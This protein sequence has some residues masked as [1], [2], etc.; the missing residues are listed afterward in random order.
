[1]TRRL[2]WAVSFLAVTVLAAGM[3]VY[4]SADGD[5]DTQPWTDL[6]TSNIPAAVTFAAIGV[7]V[8]W[9][10]PHFEHAYAK[11]GITMD[12]EPVVTVSTLTAV[13]AAVLALIA[14]FGVDLTQAQT[15]AILGL[16]AVLAPLVVG[17][18]ARRWAY[19]PATVRTILTKAADEGNAPPPWEQP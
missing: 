11:K 14:A 12:K 5:P 16:D 17:F 19:S 3:E 1:M 8:G 2:A 9:L 6:I 15:V 18:V 10:R 7:L 4:A 13:V